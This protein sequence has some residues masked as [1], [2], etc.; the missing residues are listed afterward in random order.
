MLFNKFPAFVADDATALCSQQPA[1]RPSFRQ[2]PSPLRKIHCPITL[3]RAQTWL[4]TWAGFNLPF[5]W[6]LTQNCACQFIQVTRLIGPQ[7]LIL[8]YLISILIFGTVR[9]PSVQ[10]FF[11]SLQRP[12]RPWGTPSLLFNAY[13]G[14]LSLGL[15]RKD[16]EVDNLPPSI[17]EVKKG[18]VIFPLLCMSSWHIA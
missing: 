10:E 1:I 5:V 17:A 16:R 9:F 8:I 11:S 7:L 2:H 14:I 15:K 3:T 4:L 6:K 18:G 13:R 12:D